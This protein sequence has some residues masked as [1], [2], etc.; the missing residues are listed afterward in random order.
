[1][2]RPIGSMGRRGFLRGIGVSM[3]LPALESFRPLLAAGLE[4]RPIATT[5]SGAPLRMAYMYIP[6]GV[7][8]ANWQPKGTGK[9]G[10]EGK[11]LGRKHR[12]QK[13][14]TQHSGLPPQADGRRVKRSR[15]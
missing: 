6:N 4:T 7:N 15:S 2:S 12:P 1:M 3:A 5:A 13:F 10:G 14:L 11:R 9:S 8:V